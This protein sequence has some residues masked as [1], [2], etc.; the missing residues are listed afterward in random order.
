MG[1]SRAAGRVLART[2]RVGSRRSACQRCTQWVHN[3]RSACWR[4]R[5]KGCI[6]IA[7]DSRPSARNSRQTSK[8]HRSGALGTMRQHIRLGDFRRRSQRSAAELPRRRAH[9]ACVCGAIRRVRAILPDC[10]CVF[11]DGHEHELANMRLT[12]SS[13]ARAKR[14]GRLAGARG[15]SCW[16]GQIPH[17]RD[18]RL[19]L[20]TYHRSGE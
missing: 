3:C 11:S 12:V 6:R 8:A 15:L 10:Q 9:P 1:L 2:L 16:L 7:I 19:F 18:G 13:P 4:L 20:A 17:F 14:R 5:S